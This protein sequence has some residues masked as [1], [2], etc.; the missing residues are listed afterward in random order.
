MLRTF[1]PLYTLQKLFSKTLLFW[2]IHLQAKTIFGE[3]F[4]K[5]SSGHGPNHILLFVASLN[6]KMKLCDGIMAKLCKIFLS[7]LL[8]MIVK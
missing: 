5:F 7:K 6:Q 8:K 4:H 1:F 2:V 3:Q